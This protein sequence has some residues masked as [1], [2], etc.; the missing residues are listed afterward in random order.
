LALACMTPADSIFNECDETLKSVLTE[1]RLN[2]KTGKS[3]RRHILSDSEQVNLE[4]GMVNRNKLGRK[5]QFAYLAL[6]EP[7]P[8][9]SGFAKVD[10]FTVELRKYIYGDER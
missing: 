9:V 1:T 10:L 7:C 8:K 3:T 4:A 2:L 5:I 6:A